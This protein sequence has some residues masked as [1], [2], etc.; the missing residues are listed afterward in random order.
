MHCSNTGADS[1]HED[2]D[3][4]HG[5]QMNINRKSAYNIRFVF[6]PN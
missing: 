6:F 5:K 4:D 1:Y 2:N 3:H